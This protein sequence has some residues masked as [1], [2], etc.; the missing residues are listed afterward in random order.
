MTTVTF[1]EDLQLPSHFRDLAAFLAYLEENGLMVVL[2][3]LSEDEVT[4]D[5]RKKAN[6]ASQQLM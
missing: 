2:H 4:D 6:E 1:D 3:E 5:V